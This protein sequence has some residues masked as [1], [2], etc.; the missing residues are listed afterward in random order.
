MR[1][2]IAD[3]FKP[4]KDAAHRAHK[5]VCNR[6]NETLKPL[7]DAAL[8]LGQRIASFEHQ[9]REAARIEQD[10][11]R[12]EQQRIAEEEARQEAER[13]A[14]EDAIELEAAGD[15]AAAEAVLANPTPVV[16]RYV[17]PPVV[18]TN[19]TR[20]AGAAARTTWKARVVNPNLVPREYL[21]VDESALNKIAGVMK[22]RAKVPGVEFYPE[23]AVHG[24]SSRVA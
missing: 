6:E 24:R 21:I 23:T 3:F 19:I 17:A 12:V 9:A 5:E 15:I 4:M 13:L 10:R 16:P 8:A 20:V 14:I 7:E 22:E 2:S 18:P 1:K 11:L